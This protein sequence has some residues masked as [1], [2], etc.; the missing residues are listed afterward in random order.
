M[1]QYC[2]EASHPHLSGFEL[3]Y[4]V[5]LSSLWSCFVG[6]LPCL[7]VVWVVA[8]QVRVILTIFELSSVTS[9]WSETS[10][11]KDYILKLHFTRKRGKGER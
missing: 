9:S 2:I 1:L 6:T 8:T 3:R 4:F 5:S 7:S 11:M 10:L